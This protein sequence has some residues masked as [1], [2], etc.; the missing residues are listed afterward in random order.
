MTRATKLLAFS[1]SITSLFLTAQAIAED[2][3]PR[4]SVPA[5]YKIS[6]FAKDVDNARQMAVGKDGTVYVGSRKAGKVHALIDHNRDGVA[7]KKILIAEG[8]N[9]PSGIALK[10]GDL[11]VAEVER[12]IKFS[13]IAKN[14]K[15]PKSEVVFDDLPDK[16]HHGW[17]YLTF[18]PEG[19]LIIPVGVPCN[20]C[21][22]DPKFG[23]I[24]SLNLETKK[25]ST[26]ALGV[27][28]SVGF[29]YHPK[30]G[31]LWFSDN[32]RDMMGDDIPPCELNRVDEV[33]QHF[34]FPYVHGGSVLDP[35]FGEGKKV[36]DYVMP[37]LALQAH[38]A[39]LGI[40][41]YRGKQFPQAMQH[42]LFVAEH[43]SWNRSK[44]VGYRVMVAKV[45]NGQI[46][47]YEPFITGFME[48]ETTYGRPAAI[49]E[50]ADGSLLVS[51]DYANAIYRVSYNNK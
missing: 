33:G 5:G 50:L 14:L 7:D 39:P 6:Y 40:H 9:L 29:D 18:S 15:A 17:K 44:K 32:G 27:R 24:F 38:V 37:A 35:E 30:T 8:L 42:Q 28:N 43:G 3:L 1:V 45:E 26:I 49:A 48:N 20:V 34:G 11:Y 41:F 31:K 12:I 13:Q 16:R 4:L 2:I 47:G 23:R 46:R 21:A 25:L 36:T 51:D 22:E 10:N 19:E